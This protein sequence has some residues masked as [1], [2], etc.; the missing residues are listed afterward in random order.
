MTQIN[1]VQQYALTSNTVG[2]R[3]SPT[4]GENNRGYYFDGDIAE[5][6][7]YNR[8]LTDA[9]RR[10]LVDYLDQKYLIAAMD[11]DGDGLT[12]AQ[13]E[14]MGSDPYNPDTNGNGIIDGIEVLL[15]L[16]PTAANPISLLPNGVTVLSPF[17]PTLWQLPATQ[18]GDPPPTIILSQP[19]N[20]IPQ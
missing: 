10:A 9:E 3:S 12:N 15:G 11:A 6:I 17:D 14:A 5:L 13:E 7:I 20:A 4:L 18:D 1:G 16:S 2:F 8:A 19:I